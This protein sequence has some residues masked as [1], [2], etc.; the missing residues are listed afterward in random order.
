MS[1][2]DIDWAKELHEQ[3]TSLPARLETLAK[4]AET[5]NH[6]TGEMRLMPAAGVADILYDALDEI[7]RCR[8]ILEAEAEGE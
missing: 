2:A 7:V 3:H 6:W 4:L 5:A 8:E 1:T